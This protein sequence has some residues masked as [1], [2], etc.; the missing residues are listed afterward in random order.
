MGRGGMG[1]PAHGLEFTPTPK[2]RAR[3]EK[4]RNVSVDAQS[5]GLKGHTIL[6]QGNALGPGPHN[7]ER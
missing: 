3:K 7:L 2:R 5:Y 4:A 1:I 6:A